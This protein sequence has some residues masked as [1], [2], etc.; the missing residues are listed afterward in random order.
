[1]KLSLVVCM[2]VLVGGCAAGS[3]D[4][5]PE[6]ITATIVDASTPIPEA[7]NHSPPSGI[8]CQLTT[9]WNPDAWLWANARWSC[10]DDS[11]IPWLCNYDTENPTTCQDQTCV[12]GSH[13]EAPDGTGVVLEC[14][15]D[16]Y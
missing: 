5:V 11:N 9:N 7:G 13:C 15:S 10:V 4:P 12:V 14:D 6:D 2:S 16:A 8:C 1:M 3:N